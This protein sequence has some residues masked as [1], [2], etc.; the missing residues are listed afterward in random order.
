MSDSKHEHYEILNLLGYGLAKFDVDLVRGFDCSSK[1]EFFEYIVFLGFATTVGTVKNRQDL[2]D[3]FFENGRKGWWQKGD[4]YI[5]RKILIDSLYGKLG[6]SEFVG[7]L[8]LYLSGK[9]SPSCGEGDK[10]S[11]ILKS[12]YNKLQET[13][14]E[15]EL[16]FMN[17]YESVRPFQNGRIEDARRL[18]DGYDFQIE[19]DGHFYLA[20]IKGLRS[21]YGSLRF[22]ENE[23]RKACQFKADYGLIVVSNLLD[24][25]KMA[26]IFDPTNTLVFKRATVSQEQVSYHTPPVS[27]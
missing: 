22:T 7:V 17:N 2:F 9:V 20:E 12:K 25:P 8:K 16:Y 19:V 21:N 4:T 24:A 13:G 26:S 1:V 6:V 3:P 5:H 27:W 15:A 18:G 11:P 23:Y 14:Y 10:V